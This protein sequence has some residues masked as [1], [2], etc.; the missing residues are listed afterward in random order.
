M[1]K[2]EIKQGN[3]SHLE[4]CI[5]ALTD[6][7]FARICLTPEKIRRGLT[8]GLS[9][10]EIFVALS[11][12][13]GCTGYVWIDMSGAFGYPYVRGVAVKSEHR[14]FGVGKRLLDYFEKV[15]FEDNPKVCLLVSDFNIRAK[16]FYER[17]GYQEVV[18][19]PSLFKQDVN[20][21]LM[22]KERSY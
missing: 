12:D 2:L 17:Q 6:S 15:G 13:Y 8:S 1:E 22:I 4:D 18:L 9:S 7:E 20:E 3:I 14:S 10:G 16:K 19:L 5:E 11:G 21:Y